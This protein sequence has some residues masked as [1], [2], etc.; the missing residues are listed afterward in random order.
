MVNIAVPWTIAGVLFILVVIIFLNPEKA[1]IWSA[2]ISKGLASS[3]K[4]FARRAISGKIESLV[5]G[6]AKRFDKES[7]GIMQCS[8][9]IK[10]V[11]EIDK[12]AILREEGTVFVRLGHQHDDLQK[13][14]ALAMLLFCSK[15][16]IQISRP[17]LSNSLVRSVD[18]VTTKKMLNES[19]EKG[20]VDYFLDNVMR[21]DIENDVEIKDK[22]Q[23]MEVLDDQGLY[24][25]VLLR[26][27]QELGRDLYPKT[28]AG[29]EATESDEFLE[30][31]MQI[32]TKSPD[33]D[34]E[35]FF[36]KNWIRIAFILVARAEVIA[37]RGFTPY[38]RRLEK[39]QR[40]GAKTVYIHGMTDNIGYT[41]KIAELAQEKGLGSIVQISKFKTR[42]ISGRLIPAICIT[43][44]MNL[45]END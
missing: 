18:L 34:V 39:Q 23:K 44:N 40:D 2:W 6:F 31:L 4:Y 16:L 32:A 45:Q 9:K 30:F 7:S 29:T 19:N 11:K 17:Y 36:K 5:N 37:E 38:I 35:L 26:E 21:K 14:L 42:V 13:A 27:L 43:F 24:S 33:E 20:S 25:R 41:Q 22:C 1:Q 8:L 3:N 10:W 15:S 12:E 28:P